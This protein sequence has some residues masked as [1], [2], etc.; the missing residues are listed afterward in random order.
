MASVTL[1]SIDIELESVNQGFGCDSQLTSEAIL[2]LIPRCTGS[3]ALNLKSNWTLLALSTNCKRS[4][5]SQKFLS[6]WS[7]LGTLYWNVYGKF[8]GHLLKFFKACLV[9][10]QGF[11]IS[12]IYLQF[13]SL[14]E[15]FLLKAVLCYNWSS[16]SK[17][18]CKAKKK[19]F[20]LKAAARICFSVRIWFCKIQT[21]IFF[22]WNIFFSIFTT[23]NEESLL[24]W[25]NLSTWELKKRVKSR[26][27]S[28]NT[29]VETFQSFL[30]SDVRGGK[31]QLK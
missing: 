10:L 27:I 18:W 26:L 29:E 9:F 17:Q 25:K 13:L 2:V 20:C 3:L 4:L 6:L 7:T 21:S 23:K 31:G 5:K 16:V 24:F 1:Q 30:V 11:S 15:D 19:K 8:I 14:V 12:L 28:E 22:P